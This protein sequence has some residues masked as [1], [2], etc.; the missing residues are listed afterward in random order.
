MILRMR[1]GDVRA[2]GRATQGVRLIEMEEGDA[3]VAIA[4]LAE[5]DE[6]N[7]EPDEF[8]RYAGSSFAYFA[9]SFFTPTR[10]KRTVI[11]KSSLCSST[12]THRSR[13]RTARAGRAC[14]FAARGPTDPLP[15]TGRL[16][17]ASLNRAALPFRGRTGSSGTRSGRA[18]KRSGTRTSRP[19]SMRSISSDGISSR[20]R[21]GSVDWYSPNTRRRAALVSTSCDLR[22]RHA[23]RSTAVAPPR[24]PPRLRSTANAGTGLPRARR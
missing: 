4:K 17:S 6:E 18:R 16:S 12:E 22:A 10:L 13:R 21:D 11:F 1:A 8:S 7:G 24:A 20:N 19:A 9:S 3:V 5:K 15:R 14:R 23:R 2:I